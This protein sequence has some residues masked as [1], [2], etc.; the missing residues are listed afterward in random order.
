MM[1]SS[2]FRNQPQLNLNTKISDHFLV[3]WYIDSKLEKYFKTKS[4]SKNEVN[5]STTV[6]HPELSSVLVLS[7]IPG[8]QK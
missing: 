5:D 4:A 8:E 2:C 6:M 1:N 3:N 7:A